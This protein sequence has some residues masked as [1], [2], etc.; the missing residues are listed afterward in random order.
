MDNTPDY[1]L[2]TTGIHHIADMS[3]GNMT[4]RTEPSEGLTNICF[5]LQPAMPI[6]HVVQ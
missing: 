4:A 5:L 1:G 2:N 6:R 3:A